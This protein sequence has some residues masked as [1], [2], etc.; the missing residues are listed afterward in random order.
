MIK[1]TRRRVAHRSR[2]GIMHDALHLTVRIAMG[3]PSMR[4]KAARRVIVEAIREQRGRFDFRI[5]EFA[6]LSN[7]MH[8]I[9]E[10]CDAK[11]LGRAMP[12]RTGL[13]GRLARG[14]N[15]LWRRK[16]PVFPDRF[17]HRVVRK[18]HELHELHELRGLVR[19]V[20]Q[21]A[22]RHGIQVPNNR[23]DEYSS[24]PWFPHWHGCDGRTFT[25]EPRPV[26][27][28]GRMELQCAHRFGIEL[29]ERPDPAP[30]LRDP[31]RRRRLST[32]A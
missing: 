20:L 12:M 24:G 15:K 19:Y 31:R 21:N 6:I 27:W 2:H 22:R 13:S 18:V 14:L 1:T 4:T 26:E 30:P 28:P 3:L 32:L 11:E 16:G 29:T 5:V 23:P 17:H 8:L 9:A 7:H 10:A 25:A